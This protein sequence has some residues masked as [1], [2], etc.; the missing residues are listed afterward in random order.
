MLLPYRKNT[1][2]IYSTLNYV[3]DTQGYPKY[4]ELAGCR[5]VIQVNAPLSSRQRLDQR[6]ANTDSPRRHVELHTFR[7]VRPSAFCSAGNTVGLYAESARANT[8]LEIAVVWEAMACRLLH[9]FERFG[10]TCWLH[11]RRRNVSI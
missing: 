8:R 1:R 4:R 10:G 7:G 9:R 11:L 2:P 6:F 5:Y 3:C